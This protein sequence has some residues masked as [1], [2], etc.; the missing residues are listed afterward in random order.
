RIAAALAADPMRRTELRRTLRA[1]IQGSA[2][3]DGRL[4]TPTLE[5]AFRWMWRERCAGRAPKTFDVPLADAG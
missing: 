5:A 4:F 1:R 2:L 3:G